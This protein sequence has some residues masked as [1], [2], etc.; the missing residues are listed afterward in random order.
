[1]C[2]FETRVLIQ[3]S[4][5]RNVLRMS[6]TPKTRGRPRKAD[7]LQPLNVRVDPS[8][9]E[10]LRARAEAAGVSESEV[11]RQLMARG[12]EADPIRID[13]LQ[14]HHEIK[15]ARARS[16]GATSG[17]RAVAEVGKATRYRLPRLPRLPAAA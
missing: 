11:A 2:D 12:L 14:A 3:F 8:T 15:A 13:E 10:I 9:L 5:C 17:P 6:Q 7:K 1:M 16:R 4:A